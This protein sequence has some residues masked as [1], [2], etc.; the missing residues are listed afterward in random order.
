MKTI[1]TLGLIT[2][3][4]M[5][6]FSCEELPDPAGRRGIAVVPAITDLD[7]GIF[8]SKD[9]ESSYVEFVITVP[10]GTHP[11]KITVT[12]SY[13]DNFERVI[14]TEVTS[15]PSTVRIL[16]SVAAQKIGIAL[17]DIENGDIFT[18]ELLT[19]ANGLVTRSPAVIFVAVACAYDQDLAIG[20]YHSVA[21]DWPSEGD[22]TLTADPVDPYKIYISGLGEIEGLVEDLGPLVM[23]IDPVTYSVTVPEKVISSDYYGY[24]AISYFGKGVY[25]SCDG[26]Y[27]MNFDI[28]VGAYGNQGTF[29]FTFTRNP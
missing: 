1:K 19:L 15:Y 10:A 25:S 20:S 27:S 3:I 21:P 6:F 8:D 4:I 11:D 28:S 22:I 5:I 17:N 2:T 23:H 29:G 14:I 12:G 26:N 13:N 7:P 16:S 24:G 9:L 18:F